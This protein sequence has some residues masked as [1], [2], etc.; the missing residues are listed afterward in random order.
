VFYDVFQAS[1]V[2]APYVSYKRETFL[3]PERAGVAFPVSLLDKDVGLGLEL[4]RQHDLDL[5][6]AK[7]VGHILDRA[8]GAGLADRDMAEAFSAHAP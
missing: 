7:T 4:A 5:P 8:R 1:A 3:R 2:A 6:V